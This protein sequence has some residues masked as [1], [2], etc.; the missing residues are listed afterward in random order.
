MAKKEWKKLKNQSKIKD[1]N[2]EIEIDTDEYGVSD[3]TKNLA[4]AQND[5][6]NYDWFACYTIKDKNGNDVDKVTGGYTIKFDK[7]ESGKLYYYYKDGN[8]GRIMEVGFSIENGKA[9]A[10]LNIGDPPI[11]NG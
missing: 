4:N 8:K 11:G 9:K 5:Y 1:K 10:T 2:T 3:S 6:P 7:P